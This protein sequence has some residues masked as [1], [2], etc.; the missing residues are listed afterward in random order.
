MGNDSIVNVITF[1]RNANLG[2][3]KIVQVFIYYY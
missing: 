3:T 1:I 2:R